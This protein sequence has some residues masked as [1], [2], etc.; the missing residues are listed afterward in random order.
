[1]IGLAVFS[2]ALRNESLEPNPCNIRLGNEVAKI[3]RVERD[4]LVASQWEVARWLE[5]IGITPDV[6]SELRPEGEYLDSQGVWDDA[7]KAFEAKGITEV[8]PVAQPFLQLGSVKKMIRSDGFSIIKHKVGK[9]G[10]DNDEENTQ[11]WTRSSTA[12]L[13][14]AVR[15]KLGGLH[16]H[17]G[18]QSNS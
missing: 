9:I 15:V 4:V 16:G 12:L 14:Y 5:A 17:Q 13:S 6:V 8:I 1:V 11:P 3:L 7:K 2:F 10:F 18:H